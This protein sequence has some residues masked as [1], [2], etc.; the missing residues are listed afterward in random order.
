MLA[1]AKNYKVFGG[2]QTIRVADPEDL[3]GL[4]V[5]AMV[6]DPDRKPQ[7]VADMEM[8]MSLHGAKLDWQR[9][10]EFYDIFGLRGEAS[11]LKERFE[12]A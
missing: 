4:K 10:Q 3:V 9:I 2:K 12:H 6:N 1:R 8:L 11:R 7:E 5:Q